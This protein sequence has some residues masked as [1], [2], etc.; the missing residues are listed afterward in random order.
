MILG[1][2]QSVFTGFTPDTLTFLHDLAANNRKEW[3]E[4]HREE[5]RQCVL[6]PLQRLVFIPKQCA[7]SCSPATRACATCICMRNRGTGNSSGSG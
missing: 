4:A 7:S 1:P 3:F 5:Y 6:E 2:A